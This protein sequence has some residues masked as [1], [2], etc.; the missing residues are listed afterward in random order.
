MMI[1]RK[2]SDYTYEELKDM[3]NKLKNLI[4]LLPKGCPRRNQYE[5]Q[6][7][8]VMQELGPTVDDMAERYL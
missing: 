7:M 1:E 2:L 5:L 6:L 4:E 8:A 3:Q